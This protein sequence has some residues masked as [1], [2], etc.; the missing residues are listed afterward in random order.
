MH[1]LC[2]KYARTHAPQSE[3]H[4][5]CTVCNLELVNVA[6]NDI[7]SKSNRTPCPFRIAPI[8]TQSSPFSFQQRLFP[9]SNLG[10]LILHIPQYSSPFLSI[11]IFPYSPSSPPH[12][13][14]KRR[15]AVQEEGGEGNLVYLAVSQHLSNLKSL[16]NAQFTFT[17]V[18][19]HTFTHFDLH[20]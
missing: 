10:V 14:Y 17:Q 1:H 20:M 15:V 6:Q 19:S 3:L 9:N 11:Y 8:P 18:Y 16:V 12:F 7:C 13:L 5:C 4:L 2:K